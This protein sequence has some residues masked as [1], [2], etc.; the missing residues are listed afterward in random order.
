MF[1][2]K[3]RYFDFTRDFY[4]VSSTLKDLLQVQHNVDHNVQRVSMM[5]TGLISNNEVEMRQEVSLE[6]RERFCLKF[7][8]MVIT[9][10]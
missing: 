9:Y 3:K 5:N 8:E 7:V 4:G 10:S 1:C 2:I 6:H